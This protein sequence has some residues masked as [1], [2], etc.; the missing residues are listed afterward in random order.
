MKIT[1]VTLRNFK[2]FQEETFNLDDNVVIA[3]A[4]NCGKTTLLQAVATWSLVLARWREL[5]N[6]K[7]SGRGS[8]YSKVP[9]A[10]QA[11]HSVPLRAFDLLWHGRSKLRNRIEIELT[12]D[13]VPVA[14]QIESDSSEQV[15]ICPANNVE[16][17]WLKQ[18]DNELKVVFVPAMSGLNMEE[19]VYQQSKINQ[20]LGQGKPGDVL[21]NLLAETNNN[22]D[23]WERLTNSIRDMFGY[24]LLPPNTDGA[25]IVA[26]YQ[27]QKNGVRFDIASAGS[28]FLQVLMLL[29]FMNSRQGSVLLLD[30]PDA[31]LH[32]ILQDRIYTALRAVS[33]VSNSQLIIATHS[34]VVIN[35]VDPRELCALLGKP[36]K[37]ADNA[38][39]ASLIH[40]LGALSNMD[41]T[42]A[43]EKGVILYVEGHIDLSILRAWATLLNHRLK[44]FFEKPL[45]KPTVSE[46][47]THAK[48]IKAQDHFESLLLVQ[49]DIR[50]AQISDRDGNE[51]IPSSNTALDGKLLKLCWAR[52][53]IEN[54][55]VHPAALAR[56][57]GNT[58]GADAP[59]AKLDAMQEE[60]RKHLPGA[61]VDDPMKNHDVLISTKIRKS[62]LPSILDNAGLHNLPY[63]RYAEIAAV[64]Q[65]DEIHS[66]I[67]EKLDAIA[68]HFKL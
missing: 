24:E 8:T 45:W 62:I 9:I 34:E 48:G 7:R 32:V 2:R 44:D 18:P 39:K 50:G 57:I 42:L 25:N 51:N 29:T 16:P 64:M 41:I 40:S 63:T 61:V 21:R 4:N 22:Q 60:M 46:A 20:L 35:A 31:H 26:E 13:G 6:Y 15:Y 37:L 30:E 23:A 67:T 28:G 52:Y 38:E 1:K 66:E 11:F 58:V 3:G 27:H 14:M 56:F 12:C 65:P 59:L 43:L 10:R 54:Y 53:E 33:R 49:G 47:R 5:K 36:K 17:E 19:P 68:N 55:L